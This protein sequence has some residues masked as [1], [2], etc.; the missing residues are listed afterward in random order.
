ML[1]CTMPPSA[2]TSPLIDDKPM[3]RKLA[4]AK[5]LRFKRYE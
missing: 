3:S 1:P 4:S 2:L 5:G